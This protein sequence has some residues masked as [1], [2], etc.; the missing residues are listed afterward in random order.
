MERRPKAIVTGASSGI[1]KATAIRF[2]A[3]GFDV[4]LNARRASLLHSVAEGLTPG[5]HLVCPG[6]YS[7]PT[8]VNEI[9][10]TVRERWNEVNVLVNCAGIISPSDILATPLSQWQSSLNTMVEGAM[11][12]TR[13]AVS[14]MPDGGRV[15]HVTSIHGE[16]VEVKA[17]NYAVAK[18]ALRVADAQDIYFIGRGLDYAVAMEGSLK[19]KE[20]SYVHSEAMPA[21]ELK[22]GTLALVTKGTPVIVVLTQG[23][24]YDKTMSAVQEVKARGATVLAVAH[25]DDPSID[26]FAD[27]VLRIPRTEDL[28]SPMTAV[29]PL[30]LLAYHV[31]KLRG[32]DIDQP[33][34]LAKSVTVE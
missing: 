19:L 25:D 5:N 28:L 16:R 17:S 11:L 6:D 20:I 8:V 32:H 31:A 14:L 12:M 18:A 30:Q 9:G 22:H 4:C 27:G 24:V 15:I 10:E 29:V 7:D 23:A 2:A 33:R 13:M 3:D 26:S 21:G 34:N 1:G